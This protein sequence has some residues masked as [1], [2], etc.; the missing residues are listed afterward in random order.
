MPDEQHERRNERR[1][2]ADHHRNRHRAPERG[3]EQQRELDVAHA[4]AA[5]VGERGEEQEGARAEA[6]SD[7]PLGDGWIGGD[8][9]EDDRGG[10]EH[11]PVRD[12]P[13]LEVGRRDGDERRAEDRSRGP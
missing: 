5:R 4:H 11:D 1:E 9:G 10:R 2:H 3:A 8:A 7:R 12:D 6:G 13:V